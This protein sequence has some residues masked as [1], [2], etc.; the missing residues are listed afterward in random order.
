[1]NRVLI[2]ASVVAL[3][4]GLAKAQ[5]ITSFTITPTTT[6]AGQSVTLSWTTVGA[7]SVTLNGVPESPNE[8][9]LVETPS[10][11][12]T[13]T[14][15]AIA[16][17]P[18]VSSSVSVTVAG[19][20][21]PPPPPPPPPS[22]WWLPSA[23]GEFQWEIDHPLSTSSASDM[24]TG[25]TAPT[26]AKAPATNPTVYDIDGLDNPASTVAALHGLGFKVICY[27]EVGAAENY[28]SD[29][30]QFPA[31]VLGNTMQ[32]YSAE[33]Y[34]D[35]R[36]PTVVQIIENRI[37]MCKQKGFDTVEPDID[38]SY[39]SSTGFPLTRT[40]EENYMKTLIAY[41]HSIGIGMLGKN[42]DDT[43]DTYAADMEPYVDGMLTEQCNQ[44]AT[45]NLLNSYTGKKAVWNA[46]YQGPASS[47][48][49]TDNARAGWMGTLFGVNLTGL[50]RTPCK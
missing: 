39:D 32:G 8:P 42:M 3:L 18:T 31:S 21:P 17:A 22:G 30:S 12:T 27:V 28:R 20:P 10:A 11:N 24:G 14:L 6:Q 25:Q 47:F 9:S 15:V 16:R 49:A 37:A 29:Y 44:Y 43:G 23:A 19:A 4:G 13:Y 1:M 34:I 26:G 2:S 33:R 36:S 35:I 7:D 50:P 41:A 45:C 46:E 5:T 48:C 40:I 38:E